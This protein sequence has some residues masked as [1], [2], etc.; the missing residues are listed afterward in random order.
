[1]FRSLCLLLV[2]TALGFP[3]V[4]SSG[5]PG[6]KGVWNG[7]WENDAFTTGNRDRHYTNGLRLS[8]IT[9]EGSVWGWVE[10][11]ARALPFFIEDGALRASF[12]LGQ[13]LYTPG[14]ISNPLPVEGDRPYAGWLYAATGL[15]A[16]NGRVLDSVELSLGMV[17]PSA[18]GEEVQTWIHRVIDS[19]TPRGWEHQLHDEFA[20][21]LSRERKWR[22]GRKLDHLPLLG[23]MGLEVD[24]MPHLGT[25]LGNVL[26]QASG[27]GSVRIGHDLPSDYGPPR[28]RP[29]L[30][31]SEFFAPTRRFGWYLF[32]GL[33]LRAV[34]RNLFLDGS[35][36]GHSMSVDKRILVADLQAGLAVTWDPV[37][38]VFTFVMRSEEFH[39]QDGADLFGAFSLG[40][41]L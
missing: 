23:A 19:P 22:S 39:G 38:F 34:L 36:F 37:R 25:A 24:A 41:R 2:V 35:T 6:D 7:L 5:E 29:S 20:V 15:L 31:G 32:T 30:P 4:A 17:G 13:N 14:D 11:G 27:G 1:M 21:L 3:G 9:T 26:I 16:D 10:S 28:I 12:A 18:F 8:Y 40:V 33:E